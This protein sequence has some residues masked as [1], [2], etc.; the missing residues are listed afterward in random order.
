MAKLERKA[1]ELGKSGGKLRRKGVCP[2]VFDSLFGDAPAEPL[3]NPL[4]SLEYP[5]DD[6]EADATAEVSEVLRTIIEE[7]RARRDQYRLMVDTE[8]WVCLCFQSRQQKDEFLEAVG[9]VDLG[10]KYLNG[11]EV[12]GRMGVTIEPID[13]PAREGT[14]KTPKL[15]RKEVLT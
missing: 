8:Y 15:L 1:V 10:D 7:R 3:E 14:S 2:P 11:L 9:W 6:V 13:L 5:G 12:A 4:D